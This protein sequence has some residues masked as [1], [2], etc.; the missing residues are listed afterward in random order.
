MLADKVNEMTSSNASKNYGN[1]WKESLCII[2]SL[3]NK[4]TP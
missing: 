2:E 3:W 1:N 4:I